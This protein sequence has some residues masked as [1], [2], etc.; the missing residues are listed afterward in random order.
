MCACVY[1]VCVYVRVKERD[2]DDV[3]TCEADGEGK[4]IY[5]NVFGRGCVCLPLCGV[6]THK[7]CV[8][9]CVSKLNTADPDVLSGSQEPPPSSPPMPCTLGVTLV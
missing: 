9:V 5:D 3:F 6:C 8:C 4:R 2:R 1:G 7:V